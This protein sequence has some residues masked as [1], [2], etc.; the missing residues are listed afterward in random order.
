MEVIGIHVNLLRIK[1]FL[2]LREY[3]GWYTT[4]IF[5]HTPN[6]T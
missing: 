3:Y 6:S 4:L 2:D 5:G 1:R